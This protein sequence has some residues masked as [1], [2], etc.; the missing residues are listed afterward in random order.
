MA[1]RILLRDREL[2]KPLVSESGKVEKARS[3][4]TGNGF[5]RLTGPTALCEAKGTLEGTAM[6]SCKQAGTAIIREILLG[7]GVSSSE[8][9]GCTGIAVS[10]RTP[11]TFAAAALHEEAHLTFLEKGL[12]KGSAI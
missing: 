8:L 5:R 1:E 7:Q 11:V 6:Q 2:G 9:L 10:P 4:T 3:K 12:T